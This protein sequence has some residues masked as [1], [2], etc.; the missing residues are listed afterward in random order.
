MSKQLNFSHSGTFGD[1]V[2]SLQIVKHLKGGNYFLR[3]YNID[4][5]AR[6]TFGPNAS[7]GEHTGEMTEAQ[8]ESLITFMKEQPYVNSFEVFKDQPIDHALEYSGREIVK[9]QGNYAW[10]YAK[11]LGVNA[12]HYYKEFMLD[13]WITVSDPIKVPNKPIVVNWLNRHRY[14]C[15]PKSE[16]F[17]S[18]IKKGLTE[19]GVF[20]GLP[21][22]HEE[23]QKYWNC[24][25]DFYPT[26]D[27]LE[28]A[29]VIAGGEQF[30]GTQSMCLSIAIGLGKTFICEGRKDVKPEQ[31]ECYFVRPNGH[32]I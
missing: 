17:S 1:I 9:R 20:V 28:C 19:Q 3:L 6:E 18:L 25:I 23:F 16:Y 5:M 7:A 24:K 32:Y 26:K 2:Y 21:H 8:F 10:G 11:S 29:R 4:N 14:G 31:N 27:V 12:N 22:Q 15:P 13:P 30:V